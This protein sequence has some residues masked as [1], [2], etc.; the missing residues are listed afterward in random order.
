MTK[1]IDAYS[2]N[3]NGDVGLFY[4]DAKGRRCADIIEGYAF[5][6]WYFY[7]SRKDYDGYGEYLKPFIDG[8]D[9]VLEKPIRVVIESDNW[10]RVYVKNEGVNDRREYHKFDDR[11]KLTTLLK[12]AGIQI[13]E[14]DLKPYKRY[15][16]DNKIE[17]STDFNILYFDIETDDTKNGIIIGRDEILSIAVYDNHGD[18]YFF[19]SKDGYSGSERQMLLDF[20]GFC[21]YNYDIWIGW[22]SENFDKPYI[23]KRCMKYFLEKEAKFF[24]YS[25]THIDLMQVI[26]KNFAGTLKSFKLDNV[27]SHFLNRNKLDVQYGSIKTLYDTDFQKLKEYNLEDSNLLYLLNKKLGV[28]DQMILECHITGTFPSKYNTSELLDN[29][30]LRFSKDKDV[31]F[32]TIEYSEDNVK[33]PICNYNN[34]CPG[35]SNGNDDQDI[36]CAHCH[37][38]FNPSKINDDI[39]GAYVIPPVSGLHDDV[40]TFDYKSLYPTIITTW[41]I[42][43]DTFLLNGDGY[44]G[45]VIT[46]ANEHGFKKDVDSCI[47]SSI[48]ELLSL[49]S[50]FKKDMLVSDPDSQEYAIAN[51]KQLAT[52]LLCNSM[53]GLMGYANGRY[54]RREIAESITLAGQWL[55]KQTKSWFEERDYEVVYGD[56][57]TADRMLLVKNFAGLLENITFDEL[58]ERSSGFYQDRGKEFKKHV[59]FETVSAS[60]DGV[61]FEP[62]KYIVRHLTDKKIV[63][64]YDNKGSTTITED[65]SLIDSNF[66]K[67]RYDEIEN[68]FSIS[69][70]GYAL[71]LTLDNM[72]HYDYI[73]SMMINFDVVLNSSDHNKSKFIH[74]MFK[75]GPINYDCNDK[76]NFKYLNH[77]CCLLFLLGYNYQI[78][79]CDNNCYTLKMLSVFDNTS[80]PIQYDDVDYSGYVYDI[81]VG[82]NHNFFDTCGFIGLHNTDSVFVKMPVSERENLDDLLKDLHVFYNHMLKNCF[83]IDH[84]FIELEY[85]KMFKRILLLKKKHYAGRIIEQ[86]YVKVDKTL[87]KGLEYVKKDTINIAKDMQKHILDK[88]LFTEKSELDVQYFIKYIETKMD[89]FFQGKVDINDLIITK[90]LTKSPEQYTTKG[91]HVKVAMEMQKRQMEYYVG[92]QVQ[93]IVTNDKPQQ[94]VHPSWYVAGQASASY[95]WDQQIFSICSRILKVVFPDYDWDQYVVK[96]RKRQEKKIETYKRQLGNAKTEKQTSNINSKIKNCVILTDSQKND[97]LGV[98]KK[99]VFKLKSCN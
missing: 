54:Y 83:N 80:Q 4:R 29:Y 87:I 40:F 20:F 97:L 66:K 3:R 71:S 16:I 45:D 27:A 63:H 1:Y 65:H 69:S 93:Y 99:R 73:G 98:K 77:M 48:K 14:A 26:M 21:Q 92:M 6:D 79:K 61:K 58:W 49:R 30:I 96:V 32:P 75:Y 25:M 24:K 68:L 47:S 41:N 35:F 86:D 15:C 11:L 95:Y 56:S 84:H 70:D 19:S 64:V 88:I 91:V 51:A 5:S 9:G 76:T 12:D 43:P 17:V 74:E 78:I 38:V 13:Y 72:K 46:S 34:N 18:A 85:E 31:R 28:I 82:E 33:C 53:Y 62:I 36:T 23:I 57:V 2:N 7:I 55:N 89:E 44:D 59:P 50:K 37:E 39:V 52:K 10:V 81:E 8:S 90:K 94:A 67:C 42:G 60:D 22:N